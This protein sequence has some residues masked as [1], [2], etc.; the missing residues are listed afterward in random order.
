[1][2]QHIYLSVGQR[3]RDKNN[4]NALI[5]PKTGAATLTMRYRGEAKA[6]DNPEGYKR[7]MTQ[8]GHAV[9]ILDEIVGK[10]NPAT[11]HIEYTLQ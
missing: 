3:G 4:P 10:K 8:R 11:G 1:M 2:A 5:N 7:M 9:E 6:G